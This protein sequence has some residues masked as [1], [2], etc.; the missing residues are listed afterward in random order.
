VHLNNV[1]APVLN[2]LRLTHHRQR[3]HWRWREAET[4]LI[5]KVCR[6]LM[7]IQQHKH[8]ARRFDRCNSLY[9]LRLSSLSMTCRTVIKHATCLYCMGL[10]QF[11]H[12]N[13]VSFTYVIS[14]TILPYLNAIKTLNKNL[15]YQTH[16]SSSHVRQISDFCKAQT[17]WKS[18]V[19]NITP[20][21]H[22]LTQVNFFEIEVSRL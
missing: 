7:W 8:E 6:T 16:P 2:V 20:T 13:T 11:R 17:Q 12:R 4:A 3:P 10:R 14:H 21:T 19:E 9:I 15:C 22:W 18:K 5:Y 1:N